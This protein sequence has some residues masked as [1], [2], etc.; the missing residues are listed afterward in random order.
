MTAPPQ[1]A[2]TTLVRIEVKLDHALS[3]GVDHEN[4]LRALERSRWPLPALAVLI[5]VGSALMPLLQK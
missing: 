2:G 5:A 1:D 3:V 4:R